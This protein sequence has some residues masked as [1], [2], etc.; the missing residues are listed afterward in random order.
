MS[1]QMWDPNTGAVAWLQSALKSAG[2]DPGNIDGIYGPVTS[3]AM[4]AFQSANGLPPT[5]IDDD[6]SEAKLSGGGSTT[7][8]PASSSADIISAKYGHIAW[9]VNVPEL[10]AIFDQAVNENWDEARII[11]AISA[12]PW[13]KTT[14]DTA[15]L[16]QEK[17]AQDPATADRLF[18]QQ[19]AQL[20]DQAS[21]LGISLAGTDFDAMVERS[22][23]LGLDQNQITDMLLAAGGQVTPGLLTSTQD[24]LRAQAA[25]YAVPISTQTLATWAQQIAG[26]AATP[27][28]FVS[29]LHE[30]AKSLFPALAAAIDS[31]I[32][33][34]QYAEPYVQ[35]ASNEL[36]LNPRDINL[37]DTKWS[38]AISGIDPATNTPAAMS[39]YDWTRLIRTDE[40]YGYDKTP[41]ALADATQVKDTLLKQMG[42]AA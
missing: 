31:G 6:I 9:A 4:A 37:S 42:F 20:L 2:F 3:A 7:A 8:A 5:G 32:T 13:W 12:T 22:L 10:K 39:L 1:L 18:T 11:G 24:Q 29:Y 16:W 21:Q 23:S 36:G 35:I 19:R 34:R 26:G 33:V 38:R 30:Q 41:G 40:T 27:D 28:G 17:R 14:A 25:N 15:R